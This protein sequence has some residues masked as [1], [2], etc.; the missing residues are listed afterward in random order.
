M[1]NNIKHYFADKEVQVVLGGLLRFGV[2][3]STAIV[4][5]GGIV[6]LISHSQNFVSFGHFDPKQVRFS[7]IAQIFIGLRKLDGLA[8]IQFGVL[9]LIFTPIARVVF[10]IFSF[11][12]ER[13]YMYVVI[14]LVVLGVIITS[15]YLDISH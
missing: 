8:I 11:L 13:D 9:L 14:G 1:S 12:I 7:S 10:S 2:L 5:L 15:L 3:L 4:L 6:Y